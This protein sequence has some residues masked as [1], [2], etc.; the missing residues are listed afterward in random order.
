MGEV[1][2][3]LPGQIYRHFKGKLYQIIA[4]AN[5][6][7][8]GE[9]LVI[10]Q[11]LYDDFSVWARPMEMFMSEVDRIKYPDVTQK[12]RFEKVD[13]SN[14]VNNANASMVE[15]KATSSKADEVKAYEVKSGQAHLTENNQTNEVENPEEMIE[16]CNPDLLTFL[17]ADTYEEK[18][19]VLMS[20]KSRIDDRLIDDIAASMDVMVE[21][22]DIDVRFKSLLKCVDTMMKYECTRLR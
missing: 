19:Q 10:Y 1:R 14:L 13:A 6:S 11:R 4:V 16:G 15:V 8:T 2:N 18:R 9:K 17:D 21:D 20:I 3:V 12:Y 7:E 5:H 22:G